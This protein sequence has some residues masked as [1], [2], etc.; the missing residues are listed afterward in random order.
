MF[1]V[2]IVCVSFFFWGMTTKTGA[3]PGAMGE[4][5]V[6]FTIYGHDYSFSEKVK[7]DNL[8]DLAQSLGLYQF[9][10]T[11]AGL[12]VRVRTQERV[13]IEFV[14]NWIILQHEMENLGISPTDAEVQEE[15]KKLP[16][17]QKDGKYDPALG[18]LMEK[19]IG[20][21][22]KRVDDVFDLLR[23]V[24]GL[25]KVE[26]LVSANYEGSHQF[27]DQY[28]IYQNQTIKASRIPF[29]QDDFKKTVKV[30]DEDVKNYY[31]Q[32]K[33]SYKT[34]E[35]R[36]VSYV[37]FETPK[38]PE[39]ATNEE[40][41]KINK[42]FQTKASDFS[43][44][45]EKDSSKMAALAK[46]AGVEVKTTPAFTEDAAPE[47]FKTEYRALGDIFALHKDH[48]GSE[49]IETPKG[50]YFVHLD[51]IEEPKQQELKE[52][53]GRIKEA[54]TEQKSQEAMLKAASDART[55]LEAALKEGK[56]IE[57]AAKA[58]NLK[59]EPLE[60][61]SPS[62]A[63]IAV[64]DPI[65]ARELGQEAAKTAPGKILKPI[66]G[67]HGVNLT[68]IT[69]KEMRK[70]PTEDAQKKDMEKMISDYTRHAVFSSWWD[71][72]KDESKLN[73]DPIARRNSVVRTGA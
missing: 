14:F 48:P 73:A 52:V 47:P 4:D 28:F 29:L 70:S 64:K 69:A 39:K 10:Q 26:A 15:Y 13:E 16:A 71:R 72:R 54:L 34:P 46:T 11:L 59:L 9:Y 36:S 55:A 33:D 17:L 51:S 32:K 68:Y 23:A 66:N 6:A 20:M 65:Y 3:R 19:R 18:E 30:S 67:Q 25:R 57:D 27:A 40:R 58:Q 60:D 63:S 2:A 41:E 50:Y 12:S 37:F 5:D 49:P 35:K 21:L 61:F 43:K 1:V 8:G 7:Y 56:K 53:E 24:V 22:G 31:E 45:F 42:D 62:S 44:E 38:I